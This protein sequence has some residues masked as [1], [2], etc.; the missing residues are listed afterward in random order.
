MQIEEGERQSHA[1]HYAADKVP[2]AVFARFECGSVNDD[3]GQYHRYNLDPLNDDIEYSGDCRRQHNNIGHKIIEEIAYENK[4]KSVGEHSA[5]A[6]VN[7]L[8]P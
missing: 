4:L 1:Q 7:Y 8:A 5:G 2:C 6:V 3:T